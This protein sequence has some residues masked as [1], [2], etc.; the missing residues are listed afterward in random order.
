MVGR[1]ITPAARTL[2]GSSV[3][4]WFITSQVR[5]MVREMPDSPTNMWCASSVSMNLV[6]RA[7]GSKALSAS[8]ASWNLPS[9]SVK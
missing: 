6:V 4:S 2:A 9:R 1:S 7:S 8:A 5:W 3:F